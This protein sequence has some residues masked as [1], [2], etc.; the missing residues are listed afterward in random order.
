MKGNKW[1]FNLLYCDPIVSILF[2]WSHRRGSIEKSCR[3]V[4]CSPREDHFETR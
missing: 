3:K 2:Q 1:D 4:Q